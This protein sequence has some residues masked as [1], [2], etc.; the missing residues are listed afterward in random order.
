MAKDMESTFQKGKADPRMKKVWGW[1]WSLGGLLSL[2]ICIGWAVIFDFMMGAPVFTICMLVLSLIVIIVCNIWVSLYWKNY[3][4]E[5]LNERVVIKRGVISK[6]KVSIPYERIQNV[7][8][9]KGVFERIF[10]V[11]NIQ[12]ETA[13][14]ARVEGTIQGILDPEPIEGFILRKVKAIQTGDALGDVFSR[15][16]STDP[17]L[18]VKMVLKILKIECPDCGKEF[19]VNDKRR[20]F[21]T[22]CPHCG[23]K[24]EVEQ[25]RCVVFSFSEDRDFPIIE[26]LAEENNGNTISRKFEEMI[27]S[28]IKKYMEE[29]DVNEDIAK[30]LHSGGY[31]TLE[32]LKRAIPA[33]LRLVDGITP[34]IA[35]KICARVK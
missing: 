20:P 2:W 10:N 9:V 21:E 32:E 7:N 24:G 28:T 26:D 29:L 8:I 6:R 19:S 30:K 18:K 13:G 16:K 15:S 5:F 4:F 34:T 25:E 1:R 27:P 14:G 23:V 12:I 17:P 11:S 33:D 22:I 31:W 3:S 35:R